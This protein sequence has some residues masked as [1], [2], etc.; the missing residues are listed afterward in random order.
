MEKLKNIK[1]FKTTL[2]AIVS[3]VASFYYLFEVADHKLWI[4]VVLLVFATMML[5]SADSFLKSL[6]RFIKNNEKKDI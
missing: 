2:I 6:T 1:E 3:Y 4:F 5:F